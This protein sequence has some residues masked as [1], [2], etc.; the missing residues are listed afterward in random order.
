MPIT[1]I[2]VPVFVPRWLFP[3]ARNFY[4]RMSQEKKRPGPTSMGDRDVEYSFIIGNLPPGPGKALDFGCGSARLSLEAA[5]RGYEVTALDMLPCEGGVYW[6][7]PAVQFVVGD[8]LSVAFP[9]EHFDIVMNCSAVEHVGLA[10]R[11]AVTSQR[12]TGD[13]DAMRAMFRFLKPGGLMLLT[14]PC[15]RDAVFL[16]HFRVYGKERLPELLNGFTLEK[17]EF[18]LKDEADRWVFC[19]PEQALASVPF[20]D[21]IHPV[22][23]SYALGCFVLRRPL[24]DGAEDEVRGF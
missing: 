2:R 18:W 22:Y 20:S 16:P 10:G 13:L 6:R 4:H 9:H 1:F 3:V 24:D 11:Y 15:G 8:V 19:Q 17:Q 23:N 7:H 5:E 21:P 12:D 14:V